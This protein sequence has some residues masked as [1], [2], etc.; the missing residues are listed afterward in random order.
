[1]YK[2]NIYELLW[3]YRGSKIYHM[4]HFEGDENSRKEDFME[5]Y[6]AGF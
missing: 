1:M 4:Q 5:E 6:Y 3:N 2:R